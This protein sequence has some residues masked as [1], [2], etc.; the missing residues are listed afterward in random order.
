MLIISQ[1]VIT[2]QDCET[3]VYSPVETSPC[4]NIVLRRACF[5]DNVVQSYSVPMTSV[6]IEVCRLSWKCLPCGLLCYTHHRG[7]VISLSD[8]LQFLG[9]KK[10]V[11]KGDKDTSH[12]LDCL[13]LFVT[14]KL[15]E[16]NHWL[17]YGMSCIFAFITQNQMFYGHIGSI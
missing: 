3:M 4:I 13:L 5:I 7:T 9:K 14:R 15:L 2:I 1:N 17:V 6:I 11:Q 10:H 8:M 12:E 16:N